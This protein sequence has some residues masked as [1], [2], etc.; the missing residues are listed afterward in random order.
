MLEFFLF[1][2]F[3][4]GFQ[5]F[6]FSE[7]VLWKR[8]LVKIEESFFDPN[9]FFLNEYRIGIGIKYKLNKNNSLKTYYVY[10]GEI[11]NKKIESTGIWGFK[12][13]YE[14]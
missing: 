5:N 4:I 3:K 10:K 14:L 7:C 2:R 8:A 9:F 13:E 11:E 1:T 6:E 12:Y